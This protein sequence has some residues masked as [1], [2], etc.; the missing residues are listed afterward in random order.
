MR[1]LVEAISTLSS[2]VTIGVFVTGIQSLSEF[3]RALGSRGYSP[4]V[5]YSLFGTILAIYF[6]FF[7]VAVHLLSREFVTYRIATTG[8]TV[9]LFCRVLIFMICF[10]LSLCVTDA[11]F[12]E[13]FRQIEEDRE[14]AK[15]AWAFQGSSRRLPHLVIVV[16]AILSVM[17]IVV[18]AR[19]H[20]D[21]IGRAAEPD[22]L[23]HKPGS[24]ATKPPEV[25]AATDDKEPL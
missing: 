17:T 10:L 6:L 1:K 2:V 19:V 16:Q 4:V 15:I 25:R 7:V 12:P 14:A 18:G 11:F 23:S 13:L 22:D 3:F 20:V 9:H 8:N 24:P 21:Q 5:T